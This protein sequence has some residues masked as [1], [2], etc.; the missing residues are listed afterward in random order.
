MPT[1]HPSD[2]PAIHSRS[3]A[4]LFPFVLLGQTP[5]HSRLCPVDIL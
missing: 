5:R 3:A 4:E 1:S 2:V